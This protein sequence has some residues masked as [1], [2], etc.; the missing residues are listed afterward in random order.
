MENDRKNGTSHIETKQA[1]QPVQSNAPTSNYTTE[2]ADD[3]HQKSLVTSFLLR[4]TSIKFSWEI[5]AQ[6]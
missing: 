2:E 4:R 5:Q 6:K 3:L 1:V